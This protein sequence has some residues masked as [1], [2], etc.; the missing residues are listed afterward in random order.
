MADS[1]V[2]ACPQSLL[3]PEGIQ[4]QF[5]I[6]PFSKRCL[7]DGLDDLGYILKF[8]DRIAEYEQKNR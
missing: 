8:S 7:L 4:V 1:P 2:T 6:D 5:P 3:L